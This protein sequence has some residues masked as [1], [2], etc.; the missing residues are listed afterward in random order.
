[1]NESEVHNWSLVWLGSLT[2]R[3]SDSWSKGCEFDFRLGRYQVVTTRMGDCL[4]SGKLSRYTTKH[5]GQL[6]FPFLRGRQIEYWG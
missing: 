6:R 4:Q 2:V 1:M 3:T 5:Q